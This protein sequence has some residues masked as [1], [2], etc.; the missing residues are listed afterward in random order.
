M[1]EISF[2]LG[3][4]ATEGAGV[5]ACTLDDSTGAI[6]LI[7]GSDVGPNPSYLAL[8]PDHARLYVANESD[9]T[10]TGCRISRPDEPVQILG[11]QPCH[12]RGPC[13]VSLDRTGSWLFVA[14]YGS[15]SI[16]VFPVGPDGAPREAVSTVQHAGLGAHPKRQEGPHA[17]CIVVSPDNTFVYVADLGLDRIVVYTFDEKTGA[18]RPH[19]ETL[20]AP[21]AGPRHVAWSP[22]GSYLFCAM[23]LDSTVVAY[24][25]SPS[26]GR[27]QPIKTVPTLPA[28]FT[29]SSSCAAI[30]VHPTGK[31][32][33]VSNRG[34]DSIAVLSIDPASGS[35]ESRAHVEAGGR[36]PRDFNLDRSGR[37][38]IVA[39]QDDDTAVAFRVSDE[40]GIPGRIDGEPIRVPAPVCV[41]L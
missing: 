31:Y 1:A 27:L 34:H 18:I 3:S 4:Y 26:T 5:H 39:H 25:Y 14:N 6:R 7:R 17:H 2:F 41:A 28:G 16:A 32:L 13:Y 33:Y 38:M 30:R 10:V 36:V 22:D 29:G 9:G 24:S 12:G 37:F 15:G 35:I 8:T 20:T 21:G 19:G 23:E 40:T 11:R